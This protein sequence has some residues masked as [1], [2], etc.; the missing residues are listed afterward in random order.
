MFDENLIRVFRSLCDETGSEFAKRAE[1]LVL[2]GDFEGY[3]GLQVNPADYTCPVTFKGDYIVRSFLRKCP[4][5]PIKRN[6]KK[7]AEEKFFAIERENVVTNLRL[8]PFVGKALLE[9][10]HDGRLIEYFDG[11]KKKVKALLGPLPRTL[12]LGRFGKGATFDDKG[13]GV[14]LPQKM[15][16]IPTVT[17]DSTCLLPFFWETA[18]GKSVMSN[19]AVPKVVPGNRFSVVPKDATKSRGIC[20]EPS[21]NVFL[22]LAVGTHIK[23]RLL[24]RFGIDLY[25]AQDIHKDLARSSSQ[26]G[27]LGTMDLS[28]ASDRI[29]V[30]LV[31]LLLPDDWF[32]LLDSLRSKKTRVRN[33]WH[34]NSKFSSMG[35][36]FTFEIMTVLLF[37]LCW[38][39]SERR[40]HTVSFQ[41]NVAVFGDDIIAPVDVCRD[42]ITVLPFLGFKVNVEKT[43]IQGPFR[44]SCGGDYFE[45]VD[46]RPLFIEV[47][48]NEPQ[49]WIAVANGLRRVGRSHLQG[50]IRPNALH[51]TW[52]RALDNLPK[53]LRKIR[54]PEFLGD[55]VIHD[56]V[57]EWL[58]ADPATGR[59]RSMYRATPDHRRFVRTL[60]PYSRPRGLSHYRADVQL[61]CAL[62]GVPSQG[63]VPR[64]EISG[65]RLKWVPI[66]Y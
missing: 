56:H 46:V 23:Q 64:G 21:I 12:E 57:S 9:G 31:K 51:R 50:A 18:W 38:E 33:Q 63:V 34:F 26:S 59:R 19:R 22:Q 2:D 60:Q 11:L 65:Y 61:A 48:I 4:N 17:T 5:L 52:L 44:E 41:K 15:S 14:S 55:L 47:A 53:R 43:F 25:K 66:G 32:S 3:L 62:Y 1:K 49:H 13:K 58:G 28:D 24:R 35:N 30:N 27:L 45:G 29:T 20:I 54:G 36:G 10:P 40:G 7:E 37:A 6:L 8:A 16:S 39:A 42:L